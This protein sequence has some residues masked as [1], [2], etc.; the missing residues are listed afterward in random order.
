MLPMDISVKDIK[1]E[2]CYSEL[3]RIGFD[4]IDVV[5]PKWDQREFILSEKFENAIIEK[6][7]QISGAGLKV[8]QTHLTYYPGHLPPL[9]DGSYKAFEEY[10]LPIFTKEIGLVSKMNCNIAVI[11][12]Y[13]DTSR[14]N[15]RISNL[16][17]LK[18]L[19]PVL[20]KRNV[21][22]AVENIY[23]PD[24]GEAYLS[25]A[26]DLLF[27]TDYF[28]NSHLGVCLDTGHAVTRNQD[29]IEMAEKLGGVLQAVHLHSNMPEND[30]H[31]P[32]CFVNNV[33]WRKLCHTLN[34]VGYRGAFNMEISAPEQM[35]TQT[36]LAYYTMAYSIANG[37]IQGETNRG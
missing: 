20:E 29:P 10:M 9:G 7:K 31:L 18:K 5:F 33:D 26:E 22:L 16:E 21:I 13:F 1:H 2:A 25:T 23:G 8:C 35:S 11:H 34:K 36:A 37:L 27:Y 19:L 12:L 15:S 3:K 17:L 4:G 14:E 30:L 28:Y 24:Y 6:Y 32:P